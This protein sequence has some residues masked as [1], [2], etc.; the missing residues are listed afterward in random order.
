M[1]GERTHS[2]KP[3]N[4]DN[5]AQGQQ[6]TENDL[7]C[8]AEEESVTRPRQC[9]NIGLSERTNMMRNSQESIQREKG[10]SLKWG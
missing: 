2:N 10:V 8:N 6:Y 3:Q 4:D 7:L 5:E 9:H 1:R